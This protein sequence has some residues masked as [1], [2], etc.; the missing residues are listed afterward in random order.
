MM[1][2][3]GVVLVGAAAILFL[4]PRLPGLRVECARPI[5]FAMLG[6]TPGREVAVESLGGATATVFVWS[7]RVGMMLSSAT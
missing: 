4:L 6:G 7:D 2:S 3:L 5:A 1:K